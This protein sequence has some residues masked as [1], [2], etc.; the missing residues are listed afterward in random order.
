MVTLSV[1]IFK[2][3]SKS[4]L[5]VS[6]EKGLSELVRLCLGKPLNK[7]EQVSNWEKRPLRKSQ[8]TYAGKFPWFSNFSQAS[9]WKRKTELISFQLW[10]LIVFSRSSSSLFS[11]PVSC[12][13]K[14][15]C[16]RWSAKSSKPPFF[17]PRSSHLTNWTQQQQEARVSHRKAGT[18]TTKT[19]TSKRLQML[20]RAFRSPTKSPSSLRT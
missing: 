15:T 8:I 5:S 20:N 18:L 6:T 16:S 3:S 4:E 2:S 19:K 14:W 1:S 13:W 9:S 12:N 11:A 7:S 17:R 10:T